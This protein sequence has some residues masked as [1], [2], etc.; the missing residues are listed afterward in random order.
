MDLL[1]KFKSGD[2]VLIFDDGKLQTARIISVENFYLRA[3]IGIRNEQRIS[4]DDFLKLIK[5]AKDHKQ[6][7]DG[8]TK[9][10]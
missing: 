5:A 1:R 3:K 6:K 9:K 8:R 10:D 4:K 2:Q 7:L